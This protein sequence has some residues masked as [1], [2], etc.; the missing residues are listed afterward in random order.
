MP[1]GLVRARAP[2]ARGG[3]D[4]RRPPP[5]G[6]CR[7]PVQDERARVHVVGRDR[8]RDLRAHEQPL[9]PLENV[10]RLERRRGGAACRR[11]IAPRARIGRALLD[12]GAR[13]L[14]RH[15]RPPAQRRAGARDG[16]LADD[17]GLRHA[18]HGHARPDGPDSGGRRAPAADH[19]RPGRHRPA[20]ERKPRRGSGR[21]RRLLAPRRLLRGRRSGSLH[22]G[23]EG[24]YRGCRSAPWP[25]RERRS[26]RPRRRRSGRSPTSR[27]G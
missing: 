10:R 26:R 23:H 22:P 11:R 21:R 17:Q 1:L 5:G 15:G 2:R 8:Q 14:L 20:R 18:R 19:R 13:S 27:S 6:G 16:C 4:D 25:R 24:G 7:V 9:R 3:R 12:P